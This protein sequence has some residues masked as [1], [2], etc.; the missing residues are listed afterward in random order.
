MA[1]STES[2]AT[3]QSGTALSRLETAAV[4]LLA[5]TGVLHLYAGIAEGA[6]PVF[7]AGVGFF[8]GIALYL[9]NTRRRLLTIAAIPY[10]AIQI[11]LWV[12][13]KAGNYT[14]VGYVD[15]LVQVV[16]VV[17]LIAIVVRRRS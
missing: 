14:V 3:S 7:L 1:T 15:K 4:V 9:R 16:L 11:P 12:G 6:V 17:V 10:T 13:A 2:S 5:V 8:G